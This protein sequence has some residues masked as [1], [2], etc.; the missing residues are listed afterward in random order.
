MSSQYNGR[1]Q[2]AQWWRTENKEIECRRRDA[3]E[4]FETIKEIHKSS[5]DVLRKVMMISGMCWYHGLIIRELEER[6]RNQSK[7]I[8]SK[9][10]VGATR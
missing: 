3:Q 2:G 8:T 6:L 1:F 5:T 7:G 9:K 10:K 4:Y